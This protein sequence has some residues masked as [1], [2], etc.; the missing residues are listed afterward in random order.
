[1]AASS[2][3]SEPKP[4]SALNV[5]EPEDRTRDRPHHCPPSARANTQA[6]PTSREATFATSAKSL[7]NGPGFL[8]ARAPVG[9]N[10]R[11]TTVTLLRCTPNIWDKNSCVRGNVSLC[12]RSR[13]CSSHRLS[14]SSNSWS[15]LHAATCWVWADRARSWSTSP[16]RRVSLCPNKP[17]QASDEGNGLGLRSWTAVLDCIGGDGEGNGLGAK[18]WD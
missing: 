10:L 17:F 5:R 8:A 11:A 2:G 1:M 9:G 13:D 3:G 12:S 7:L 6:L 16:R 15:A 18:S 4:Y 14:R